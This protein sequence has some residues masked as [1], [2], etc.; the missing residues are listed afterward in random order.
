MKKDKLVEGQVDEGIHCI[1]DDPHHVRE[2]IFCVV[3]WQPVLTPLLDLPPEEGE[4]LVETQHQ[5]LKDKP[6]VL[7]KPAGLFAF[8]GTMVFASSETS[9]VRL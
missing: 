1:P 2:K 5:D 9:Q 8:R 6:H 3:F 4:E 7:C